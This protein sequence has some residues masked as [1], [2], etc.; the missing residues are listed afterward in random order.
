MFRHKFFLCML[1]LLCSCGDSQS[2]ETGMIVPPVIVSIVFADDFEDGCI[3]RL[4]ESD[5][6]RMGVEA[7]LS[8]STK[9]PIQIGKGRFLGPKSINFELISKKQ[10]S[11]IV[12]SSIMIP[13]VCIH[14]QSETDNLD[15]QWG[16]I[17]SMHKH[18]GE[19]GG[20]Q[21][22][23]APRRFPYRPINIRQE[24]KE[25]LAE[26]LKLDKLLVG[27]KEGTEVSVTPTMNSSPDGCCLLENFLSISRLSG[28]NRYSLE[29]LVRGLE[30]EEDGGTFRLDVSPKFRTRF[31]EWV[32]QANSGNLAFLVDGIVVNSFSFAVPFR[33]GG[34]YLLLRSGKGL[35]RNVGHFAVSILQ[36]TN[37]ISITL[38]K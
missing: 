4:S 7:A 35:N 11:N 3:Q 28:E 23:R 24:S 17:G 22:S 9:S 25:E 10:F 27:L 8:I 6:F 33:L 34:N 26:F 36:A 13:E 38:G 19:S 29:N 32:N 1:L 18:D 21:R 2:K 14:E 12:G 20:L 15:S 16:P 30:F 5:S 31:E 37:A